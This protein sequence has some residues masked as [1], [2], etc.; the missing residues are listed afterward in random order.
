ML[1]KKNNG[2]KPEK[3]KLGQKGYSLVELM[4]V[5]AIMTILAAASTSVYT[6]YIEKAKKTVLLNTG[7]QIKEALLVCEM[8]Y[9]ANNDYDSMMFWSKEFLAMP[10]DPES[11]LY[12]YVGEATEDCTG[13]TL[14]LGKGK[15]GLQEIKGFTYETA[16]YRLIWDRDGDMTVEKK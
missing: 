11:V 14:K 12:P 8:D 2:N 5:I 1:R 15:S 4:V 13:Y 10:N 6:G 16:N 3:R 9:L 7:Y